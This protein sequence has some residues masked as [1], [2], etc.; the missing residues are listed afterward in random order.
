LIFAAILDIVHF[1]QIVFPFP[2][3]QFPFLPFTQ[4]SDFCR[5]LS[6]LDADIK[7]EAEIAMESRCVSNSVYLWMLSVIT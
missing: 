7:V 3:L 1:P 5:A 2:I 6:L 4:S